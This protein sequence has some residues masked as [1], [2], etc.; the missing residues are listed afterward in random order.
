MLQGCDGSILL[1]DT[2][3]FTGEQTARPNNNSI[4]GFN[5]V[6]DIKSAVEAICPNT[7]SCADILA[8]V[9][10]DGVISVSVLRDHI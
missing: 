4:R 1:V 2:P 7:V 8:L 10:R 6:D 3:T 5:V 9:A